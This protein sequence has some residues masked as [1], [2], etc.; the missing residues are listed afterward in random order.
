MQ[1]SP[2][3]IALAERCDRAWWHRY[4]DGLRPPEL[5]WPD[6]KAMRARGDQLP[7][8]AYSKALGTEMHRL[9]EIHLTLP[10]RKAARL[11][12]WN[13]LPGQCLAELVPHLPPAGSV[14]RRDV[15]A[16]MSVV[17]RGVRFR[18]LIDVVGSAL[19]RVVEVMDH[20]TSRDIRTYALLPHAVALR[21]KQPKRSL[22]DDLQACLYVLARAMR[23]RPVAPGGLCRWNYS[24]TQRTR[25]AL[26]VVQFIPFAHARTVAERASYV[27]E[28]VE[29]FRKI[30]DATPNTL[31]CDE[32]GGCW[33]RS[34]GHCRVRRKW[35]AVFVK[36]ERE[37]KE[38][39][40]MG[41]PLTFKSLGV[42]TAKVNEAEE[43]K[44]KAAD[45]KP[46]KRKS[47]PPPEPEEAEADADS[48]DD[49]EAPESEPAPAPAKRVAK[50]AK[51]RPSARVRDEAEDTDEEEAPESTPAK[52]PRAAA[53]AEFNSVTAAPDHIL[54]YFGGG[55]GATG[56]K[57][58][59]KIIATAFAEL[60]EH[61]SANLPRNPER[62]ACLRKLLEAND[63]AV[64]AASSEA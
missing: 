4:R 40:A 49:D 47:A 10:P 6:A 30:D 35:G 61:L 24:E 46:A 50:K 2:S 27:A 13:D 16:R 38:K 57:G 31:A 18:G 21:T 15:E 55:A 12:D 34:E 19:Q 28:R 51:Q 43:S 45:A 54:Q 17:V 58:E 37:E 9:A 64:R 33:Y 63:C 36:L 26:P 62:A 59:A 52:S 5:S 56:A 25:R 29:S 53:Q 60:A 7:A 39:K 1:H 42:A 11:I 23:T 44:A 48:E 3:S 8:G 32:Y 20:K 41:K 14:P 22:R